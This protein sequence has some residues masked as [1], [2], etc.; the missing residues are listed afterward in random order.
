MLIL[1]SN[2][3]SGLLFPHLLTQVRY[4]TSSLIQ[5]SDIV[6][7]SFDSADTIQLVLGVVFTTLIIICIFPMCLALRMRGGAHERVFDLLSSIDC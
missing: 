6:S 5:F 3:H 7:K 4:Q 1:F 2:K